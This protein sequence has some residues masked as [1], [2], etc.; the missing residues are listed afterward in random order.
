MRILYIK[1]VGYD[2]EQGIL[3]ACFASDDTKSQNP[4]DYE[5]QFF[6][7][8]SIP[9]TSVDDL[10][11]KI[12]Q[13]GVNYVKFIALREQYQDS[14]T[15]E[16]QVELRS[17]VGTSAAYDQTDVNNMIVFQPTQIVI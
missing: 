6:R 5:I 10:K 2:E 3:K 8:D 15:P 13:H 17:L 1:Y 4:E 12:A 11:I 9:H 7:L 14:L 16:K